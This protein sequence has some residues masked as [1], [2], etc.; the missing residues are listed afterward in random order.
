V[1]AHYP[2]PINHDVRD[3]LSDLL[4][5]SIDVDKVGRITLEDDEPAVV[6]EYV[7][8]DGSVG[9]LCVVDGPLAMRCGAALSMVPSSVADEAVKRS[10]LPDTLLENWKEVANVF[11]Q[12][13]NGPKT[14][15]LRLQALHQLPGDVPQPVDALLRAPEFRRDFE[16]RIEDYGTGRFSLLVA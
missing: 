15:H 10:E 13:L 7:T 2:A 16:L 3:L 1:T 6:A 5:R 8:D 14:P 11:A 9:A 4:G 12:L